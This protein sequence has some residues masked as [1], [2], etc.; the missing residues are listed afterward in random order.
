[1]GFK[2]NYQKKFDQK[3]YLGKN[4]AV[5]V[6]YFCYG[7]PSLKREKIF[8]WIATFATTKTISC[9]QIKHKVKGNIGI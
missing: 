3:I 2:S 6:V 5:T 4:A 7:H 9:L 1:M 8:H